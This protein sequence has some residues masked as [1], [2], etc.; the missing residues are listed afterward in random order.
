VLSPGG[1]AVVMLYYRDSFNYQVNLRIIRRLRAY[2]LRMDLGIKLAR[3][4][5]GETEKALRRHAEF[6][7]EDQHTYLDMQNVLNR[8]TDGPDNPLSQVFSKESAQQMFS[9]FRTLRTEVMFWNPNWLPGIGKLLSRRIEDLLASR[10]GWH[11]WI[12]AQKPNLE[13][14]P[15]KEIRRLDCF[16]VNHER[17]AELAIT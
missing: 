4:I 10:W 16:E 11:L 6:I 8:N 14:A 17:G 13:F 9:Q 1:R 2:L 12:Y 5:F 15:P 7:R 3:R